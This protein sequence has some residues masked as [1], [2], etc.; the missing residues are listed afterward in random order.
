MSLNRVLLKKSLYFCEKYIVLTVKMCRRNLP[1]GER[2][3]NLKLMASV[4]LDQEIQHSCHDPVHAP[5]VLHRNFVIKILFDPKMSLLN[6]I[7]VDRK[8]FCD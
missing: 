5:P 1:L 2:K 4:H 3:T 7:F 6:Y 8:I